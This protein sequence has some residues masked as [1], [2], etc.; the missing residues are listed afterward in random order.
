M[1]SCSRSVKSARISSSRTPSA[2][3]SSTSATRIRSPRMH[4]RPPQY[5]GFC[6]IRFSN[7]SASLGMAPILPM[8]RDPE[9]WERLCVT[10]PARLAAVRQAD[11]FVAFSWK[12][13]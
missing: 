11:G 1:S 13:R 6:V 8:A 5:P 9:T 2:S 4:G 7:S 10:L 12:R 3:I